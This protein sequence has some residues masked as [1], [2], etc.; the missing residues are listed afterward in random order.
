MVRVVGEVLAGLEWLGG[1]IVLGMGWLWFG[2]WGGFLGGGGGLGVGWW[3][4]GVG[5]EVWGLGWMG[6]GRRQSKCRRSR[7]RSV[8]KGQ[9]SPLIWCYLFAAV[10]IKPVFDC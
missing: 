7:E 9:I 2:G 5:P 4:L 3:G 8:W 6:S 10:Y 1:L